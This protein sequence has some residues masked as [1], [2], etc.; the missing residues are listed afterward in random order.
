M[1]HTLY[2]SNNSIKNYK[3]KNSYEVIKNHEAIDFCEVAEAY[4]VINFYKVVKQ[5][6]SKIFYLLIEENLQS[7]LIK[8]NNFVKSWGLYSIIKTA[9]YEILPKNL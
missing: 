9:C 5:Y 3:V 1:K 2:E 7:L 8:S 6:K 4:E